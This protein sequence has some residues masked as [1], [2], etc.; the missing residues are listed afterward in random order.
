MPLRRAAV[1]MPFVKNAEY[2][3][4]PYLQDTC[5]LDMDT[6]TRYSDYTVLP[7][8]KLSFLLRCVDAGFGFTS[9]MFVLVQLLYQLRAVILED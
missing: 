4:H 1:L 2:K 3:V 8:A 5:C 7:F 6:Q 9:V